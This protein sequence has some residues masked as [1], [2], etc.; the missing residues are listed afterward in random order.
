M[1]RVEPVPVSFVDKADASPIDPPIACSLDA[2][3]MAARL[4]EWRAVLAGADE[5]SSIDGGV[6]LELQS[7]APLAEIARLVEAEHDCCS[8]FA[9]AITVD[10]RGVGLEVRA[11]AGAEDLVEAVF[12]RP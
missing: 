7:G 10:E 4:A 6:R 11:P 9:F 3:D 12:G 2:T 1:T 5:R 8:F